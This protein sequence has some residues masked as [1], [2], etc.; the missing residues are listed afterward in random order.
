MPR[1]PADGN[2]LRRPWTNDFLHLKESSSVFMP[3]SSRC[4]NSKTAS[5]GVDRRLHLSLPKPFLLR[6]RRRRR[7]A[8]SSSTFEGGD[9]HALYFDNEEPHWVE[10]GRRDVALRRRRRRPYYGQPSS[11]DNLL[12]NAGRSWDFNA[13]TLNRLAQGDGLAVLCTHL[14]K[15]HGLLSTFKL[16]PLTVWRFFSL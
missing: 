5:G 6:R 10:Q 16:D 11:L 13:F 7:G 15:Y 4:R 2:S 12:T 3:L 1:P 14:F 8:M 9:L